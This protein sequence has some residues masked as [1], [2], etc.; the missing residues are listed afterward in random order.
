M[1][2]WKYVVLVVVALFGLFT[3]T[4]ISPFTTYLPFSG[5]IFCVDAED[6]DMIFVQNGTTGE[7]HFFETTEER[8]HIAQ[9]LES[10]R[11]RFWLPKPP[12]AAGGWSWRVVLESNGEN[13]TYYFGKDHITVN[14]LVYFVQEEQLDE[15][16]AYVEP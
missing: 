14:G 7:Q 4:R 10:I 11:Y 16:R 1:K 3:A 6:T 15:L 9:Q 5:K 2:K 13:R 8:A 12:L